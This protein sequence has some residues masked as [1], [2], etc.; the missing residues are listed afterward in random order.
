M[1]DFL[2]GLSDSEVLLKAQL[3]KEKI[4][5]VPTAAVL[6]AELLDALES[7]TDELDVDLENHFS[8]KAHA[9]SMRQKKDSSVR[10]TKK[11]LRN[12]AGKL[13]L[14]GA[15]K[16]EL[17]LLQMLNTSDSALPVA[18]TR[19]VGRVD[20]SERFVHTIYI[21]DEA[22]PALKRKPRGA[23]GCEIYVKIGGEP[24][25]HIK[26]CAFL[27]FTRKTKYKAEFGG[28]HVG[29]QAH[30]ILRWHLKDDSVSPVSETVSATITG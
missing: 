3:I 11:T 18:A 9:R 8:A 26:E 14:N 5:E 12:V 24:P 15:T 7:E 13:R 4:S 21:A 16:A 2:S 6:S 23:V 20:T 19:P 22:A 25:A 30:Y 1:P 10:K 17:A 29:K 27:T 28:E